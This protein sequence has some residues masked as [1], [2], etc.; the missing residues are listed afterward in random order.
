[1][2]CGDQAVGCEGA[3]CTVKGM[4]VTF[5]MVINYIDSKRLLKYLLSFDKRFHALLRSYE[6]A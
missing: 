2:C 1:M 4:N 5:M 3:L 6:R